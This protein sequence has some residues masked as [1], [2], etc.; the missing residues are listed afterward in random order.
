MELLPLAGLVDPVGGHHGGVAHAA[1]NPQAEGINN[2]GDNVDH[3]GNVDDGNNNDD[4]DDDDEN[5]NGPVAGTDVLARVELAKTVCEYYLHSRGRVSINN[6]SYF[7]DR[8]QLVDTLS[9]DIGL[10]N[11]TELIGKFLHDQLYGET[12][13]L[14]S[15]DSNAP[16]PQFHGKVTIYTS[17]VATFRAPS[18]ICG[19][20]GMYQERIHATPIWRKGPPR[21]DSVFVNTDAD[22]EG[23]RGL[24]VARV[25]L[26][27]SFVYRD[28]K[29]PCALVHWM[30]RLGDGPDE[31]T[32]M[33]TVQPDFNDDGSPLIAIIHLDS[34]LRCA[35]LIGVY[36]DVPIPKELTFDQSLDAFYAFYVNKYIDHHAFEIAF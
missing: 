23:M 12:A 17:A 5:D 15:S 10:P 28:S 27:F 6:A 14:L 25:F 9:A 4:D 13:S 1:H 2:G 20:G 30:S 24:D 32:G 7:A 35:H 8:K 21:Y 36:G 18:D 34:I 33:W 19:V 16:L 3:G 22:A 26:F 11:L 31:N 29:Y